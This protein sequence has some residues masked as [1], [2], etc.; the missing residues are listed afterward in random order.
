MSAGVGLAAGAYIP[1]RPVDTDPVGSTSSKLH[2]TTSNAIALKD[3]M[4]NKLNSKDNFFM[5]FDFEY[6]E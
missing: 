5:I 3:I 4:I 6:Y 2:T 1:L